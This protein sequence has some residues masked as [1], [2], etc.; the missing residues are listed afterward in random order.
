MQPG[1]LLLGIP[2]CVRWLGLEFDNHSQSR[3]L[4]ISGTPE[5]RCK[6]Q[7]KTENGEWMLLATGLS[8]TAMI[9]MIPDDGCGRVQ[10]LVEQRRSAHF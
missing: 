6:I 2:H 3:L 1:R 7:D 4:V 10:R 8:R 5:S 9:F